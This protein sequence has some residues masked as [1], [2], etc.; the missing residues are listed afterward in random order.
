MVKQ[1]TLRAV[2]LATT[3][4]MGIYAMQYR[5]DFSGISAV[6]TPAVSTSLPLDST[7]PQNFKVSPETLAKLLPPP[8]HYT[9]VIDFKNVVQTKEPP[10]SDLGLAAWRRG[11]PAQAAQIFARAADKDPQNSACAFWAWRAYSK[12]GKPELAERYLQKAAHAAPSFYSLLA[13]KSLQQP[14]HF[15]NISYPVPAWKLSAQSSVDPALLYALARRESGFRVQATSNKGARGVLQIMPSTA[16]AIHS[17]STH[18]P[19]SR[20]ALVVKLNDPVFNISLGQSYLQHL[21]KEAGLGNNLIYILAAYNAG[22][23]NFADWQKEYS[24][25]D[26]LEF[27]ERIPFRETRQYV[28]QVLANYWVYAQITGSNTQSAQ[29]LLLGHWPRFTLPSGALASR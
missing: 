19:L 20:S 21:K 18:K 2:L 11:K 25:E 26:P 14:H 23:G 13:Q 27:I 3:L 6:G 1:L 15:S 7:E 17:L 5:A 24:K 4:S 28:K 29:A 10:V 16:E 22:P 9:K 12:A 8:V